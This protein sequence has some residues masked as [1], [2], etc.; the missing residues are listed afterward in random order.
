MS[1]AK[2][3]PYGTRALILVVG[4]VV[5]SQWSEANNFKNAADYTGC[6]SIITDDGKA[7]CREVQNEKNRQC[8]IKTEGDPVAHERLIN[9]YK[10]AVDRFKDG[11]Y[12]KS[13]EDNFKRS[14]RDMKQ[15]IDD[16]KQAAVEGQ[17]IANS[18]IKARDAVQTWFEKTAIPLTETT[19]NNALAERKV[20]LER[21]QEWE[22]RREDG[23][24]RS[25]A[26]RADLQA[27]RD[28]EEA[29]KKVG[30]AQEALRLF[31]E[32][33][34]P[35]VEYW[36]D[37][38]IRHYNDEKTNHDTPAKQAEQRLENL[39]KVEAMSYPSLPF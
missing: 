39:K 6:N 8:N 12:A 30:E 11:K 38:L 2:K 1:I 29:R 32:K 10:E 34:G 20:L 15:K 25:E 9:E 28:H 14:I 22:K 16:R 35:D 31:N 3:I 36:A 23:K 17:R 4:L 27:E 21:L 7:A 19:R 26:N 33:Y 37:R 5:S 24:S 13:D 18:C